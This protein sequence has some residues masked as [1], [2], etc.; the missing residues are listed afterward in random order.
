MDVI[1]T[2]KCFN[3][4][5]RMEQWFDYTNTRYNSLQSHMNYMKML[6]HDIQPEI[7]ENKNTSNMLNHCKSRSKPSS[8]GEVII[9]KQTNCN[10]S[11]H[12]LY[13]IECMS[14]NDNSN[15]KK[16][17]SCQSPKLQRIVSK[18]GV[19]RTDGEKIENLSEQGKMEVELNEIT[20]RIY[21]LPHSLH[22]Q[23]TSSSPIHKENMMY[24]KHNHNWED[25]HE[26]DSTKYSKKLMQSVENPKKISEQSILNNENEYLLQNIS[27]ARDGIKLHAVGSGKT[28]TTT[29]TATIGKIKIRSKSEKK[30]KRI[31]SSL[32]SKKSS[33]S[34]LDDIALKFKKRRRKLYGS[35]SKST[36]TTRDTI[37]IGGKDT[38]K[39][40]PK[41][42]T[43]NRHVLKS[44][45]A[46][47]D[48]V[49][50]YHHN[51]ATKN[52]SPSLIAKHSK[53]DSY[54]NT[55][56]RLATNKQQN[57]YVKP[58]CEKSNN[59]HNCNIDEDNGQD[60]FQK[61]CQSK[62][63]AEGKR[64]NTYIQNSNL[65]FNSIPVCTM[66][67]CNSHQCQRS[68]MQASYCDPMITHSYE[69]P[70]FASKLK[71]VLS[72]MKTRQPTVNGITPLLIR[73]VSRGIKPVSTLMKQIN[74]QCNKLPHTNTEIV[75]EFVQKE[76]SFIS[77]SDNL[78]ENDFHEKKD[79]RSENIL[80]GC[81]AMQIPKTMSNAKML[82]IFSSQQNVK[83]ETKISGIQSKIYE[84]KSIQIDRIVKDSNLRKLQG[85][86]CN[87]VM[88]NT[89][90]INHSQDAKGIREVLIN[91]HDQFEELNTKYEKL[92]GKKEKGIDKESEKEVLN[93][94]KELTAKEDEINAVINLYKEVMQLKQQMRLLQEKNS[95]V[96]IST[97][98]PLE[99]N[100]TYSSTPFTLFKPNGISFQ[101]KLHHRRGNSI[102]ATREPT[103][104]RLVGLLRQIQTFQKQLKLTS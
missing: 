61:Q 78:F 25:P 74:N 86:E 77:G 89:P 22:S 60:S 39:R 94:E 95:Y 84:V 72:I 92:Q 79:T 67:K 63:K 14:A 70:T 68:I 98:I 102:I 81:N 30:E 97:E 49:E 8:H 18:I 1:K 7:L 59:V 100:K 37:F 96:C 90:S 50:I 99:S 10:N 73:K 80:N 23:S 20:P 103:S 101:Q 87:A 35:N 85:N 104:I 40:K 71:R 38:K 75:N 44:R 15:I 93:L 34:K 43:S 4:S 57:T 13:D 41:G 48:V 65:E 17:N 58:K 36:I 46:S 62:Y 27:S 31:P 5:K 91:L 45:Q 16:Y 83:T 11:L 82:K 2:K 9:S 24:E 32:L 33:L 47:N 88:F 69:M 28:T 12:E 52:D 42:N 29:T 54:M 21:R 6:Y 51:T 26:N 55:S 64:T 19:Q 53:F 76:N 56:N 3:D 66:E